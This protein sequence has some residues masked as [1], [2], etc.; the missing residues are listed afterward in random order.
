VVILQVVMIEKHNNDKIST[1][2]RGSQRLIKNLS[3]GDRE[4]T[5]SKFSIFSHDA[6]R[7][8]SL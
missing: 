7:S 1:E 5:L 8:A 2:I 4:G 6:L 3:N